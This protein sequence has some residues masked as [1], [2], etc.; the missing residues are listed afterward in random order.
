[1]FKFGFRKILT[2]DPYMV[3]VGHFFFFF[4]CLKNLSEFMLP[5]MLYLVRTLSHL[6][7][8]EVTGDEVLN[9]LFNVSNIYTVGTVLMLLSLKMHSFKPFS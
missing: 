6:G 7:K 5:K 8:C 4:C 3:A 2:H 1:M 9:C